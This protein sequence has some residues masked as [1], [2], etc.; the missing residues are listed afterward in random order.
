MSE[1]PSLPL[2][3]AGGFA[4]GILFFGGL[5]LTV[6]RIDRMKNP[7]IIISLSSILRTAPVLAAFWWLGRGGLLPLLS[8]LAGFLAARFLIVR[9]VGKPLRPGSKPSPGN[10]ESS[11]T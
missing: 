2:P 5:W 10:N 11:C 8:C 6:R 9:K 1:L 4:A 7:A 3:L